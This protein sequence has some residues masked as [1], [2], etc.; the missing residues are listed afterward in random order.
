MDLNTCTK[1]AAGNIITPKCRMSFPALFEATNI[2][3]ETDPDKRK[4]GV[5]LLIPD[6]ADMTLL[7][8]E[9]ERVISENMTEAQRKN[10]KV[11][12]P[13]LKTAEQKNMDDLAAEFKYMLRLSANLQN[14]PQVLGPDAQPCSEPSEVYGGRWARCS[15]RPYFWDH[16]TGGK[17][18]SFGLQNV[19]LLDHDEPFSGRSRAEDEFVPVAGT[20]A[21]GEG[22]GASLDDLM[23]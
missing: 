18:V 22:S 13:F 17:G 21:A 2:K 4:Y 7:V 10:S 14:R 15:V 6:T 3:G 1:T 12:M 8:E 9:V 20:E 16:P 11:K 19:Q 23:G 5:T